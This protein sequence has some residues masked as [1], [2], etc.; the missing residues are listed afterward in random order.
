MSLGKAQLEMQLDS[1]CEVVKRF[2]QDVTEGEV[3]LLVGMGLSA[4]IAFLT[5]FVG[6]IH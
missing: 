5:F 1:T 3:P 4:G 2:G 6:K